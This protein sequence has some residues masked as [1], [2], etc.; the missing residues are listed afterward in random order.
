MVIQSSSKEDLIKENVEETPTT[1]KTCSSN[2]IFCIFIVIITILFI[3]SVGILTAM[4][5]IG[6]SE[7]CIEKRKII[8]IN[9]TQCIDDIESD[10]YNTFVTLSGDTYNFE[11]VTPGKEKLVIYAKG[12]H[13]IHCQDLCIGIIP[14]NGN[15]VANVSYFQLEKSDH[16][17]LYRIIGFVFL[18]IASTIVLFTFA[19]TC[20]SSSCCCKKCCCK[21]NNDI[22]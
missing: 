11:C 6:Y 15:V 18:G 3:A 19:S 9:T 7:T 14:G 13:T 21:K 5:S 10:C 1:S 20:Y 4:F 8:E 12:E 2:Y 22:V 16:E 17:Q